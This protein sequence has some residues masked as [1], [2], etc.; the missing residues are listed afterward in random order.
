MSYVTELKEIF[1]KLFKLRQRPMNSNEWQSVVN[2]VNMLL[3]GPEK[4][5]ILNHLIR[6]LEKPKNSMVFHSPHSGEIMDAQLKTF[7]LILSTNNIDLI[8]TACKKIVSTP[9]LCKSKKIALIAEP[10]IKKFPG[11]MSF[12]V[13]RSQLE[14]PLKFKPRRHLLRRP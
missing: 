1:H 11:L 13:N 14:L 10:V 3:R 8:R 9:H 6:V 7:K 5:E 12:A 2:D 4:K